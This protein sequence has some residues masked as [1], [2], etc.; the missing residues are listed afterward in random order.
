VERFEFIIKG[1]KGDPYSVTF[2]IDGDVAHAFCTCQ[3]GANG[4]YCKHRFSILDGEITRLLSSN[5][6]D[7]LRLQTRLEAT[8]LQAAY[9]DLVIAQE[10]HARASDR[11]DDARHAL[12]RAMYR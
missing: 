10:E 11:L 12:S 3:A 1:S 2:E 5:T 9:R 7:V 8:K 4:L 6:E